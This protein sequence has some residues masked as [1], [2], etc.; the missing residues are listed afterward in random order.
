MLMRR[1][2]PGRAAARRASA[3]PDPTE[4]PP[5]PDLASSPPRN[6]TDTRRA[7]E[8][9]LFTGIGTATETNLSLG[10]ILTEAISLA[11]EM[12]AFSGEFD[13]SAEMMRTRADQFV[14]SVCNLQSQS[15]VIEERLATAAGAVDQAHARSRSALGSVEEL[16]ASIA[17]IERAIKMIA[18]IAAQTNLLALNA[19]IEAARAGAAGAG[20]R[21]VAGE[22]KSLSQQT[23]RATDEIVASVKRIRERAVVNTAEVRAFESTIGSL[24]DVFTAV[25]AA[26]MAQGE[27]TREIGLGS[28]SVASLAQKVRAS[29]GRMRTLGGTVRAMTSS[30]EQAAGKARHAF[31][32][33]TE[34]AI[35]LLRQGSGDEGS[36][37]DAAT[38]RWPL[39]LEGTLHHRGGS[40]KVHILDL[41]LDGLQLATPPELQS[42]VLGDTVRVETPVLG[43]FA[44]RLLTPTTAGF[45]T[46]FVE[47]QPALRDR[48]AEELRRLRA[49]YWPYVERVQ[50]IAADVAS[51]IESAVA[52]GTLRET[53]LF[54]D[55]YVEVGDFDPAEY[56]TASSAVLD[57]LLAHRLEGEL[58]RAPQPEFC[59]L[60][61]RNGFIAVHNQRYAQARRGRDTAW[62]F[63]HSRIRRMNKERVGLM[64]S[65]SFR[66]F[67]VQSYARNMGDGSAMTME[68]DAPVYVAGRHWG[69]VRMAYKMRAH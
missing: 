35:I 23:Q 28:E 50:A 10:R 2:W 38:E 64:A 17:E 3:T 52:A 16:M 69:V 47:A 63:R 65:R 56:R 61:D 20:F 27:Q 57:R 54:D 39:M 68:F 7:A 67:L 6:T 49:L 62:N 14:A 45:E 30:A 5:Q 21:V 40:C 44:I 42:T 11:D 24:E 66:P 31:A 8:S 32:R 43:S 15:D 37:R 13:T 55:Q 19:T 1:I 41:S 22:V 36:E 26:M 34:H 18:A 46:V 53:E 9:D 48:I 58:E 51:A 4:P 29:A 60:Q 59:L 25:R 33:L 12:S